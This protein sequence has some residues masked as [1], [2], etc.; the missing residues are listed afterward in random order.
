MDQYNAQDLPTVDL[1]EFNTFCPP[2]EPFI[3]LSPQTQE[4]DDRPKALLNVDELISKT[5]KTI[6]K[7]KRRELTVYGWLIPVAMTKSGQVVTVALQ[8]AFQSYETQDGR[9]VAYVVEPDH[10]EVLRVNVEAK[11]S[12]YRHFLENMIRGIERKD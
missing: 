9:W 5:A 2:N 6:K 8:L 12:E 10:Y 11:I 7:P 1:T 3:A 4:E